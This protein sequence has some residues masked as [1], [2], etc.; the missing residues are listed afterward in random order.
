MTDTTT[1]KAHYFELDKTSRTIRLLSL[2][3]TLHAD[4]TLQCEMSTVSLD[5]SPLYEALSYMWGEPDELRFQIRINGKLVNI[6]QNL[7]HALKAFRS[8]HVALEYR[9][10]LWID[11]LCINQDNIEERNH[12]VGLMGTI[13]RRARAVLIWLGDKDLTLHHKT[14]TA[15]SFS[16]SSDYL[17]PNGPTPEKL[18]A[19]TRFTGFQPSTSQQQRKRLTWQRISE[20]GTDDSWEEVAYITSLPYWQRL[21]IVQEVCL[22]TNIQIL[23]GDHSCSWDVFFA[24]IRY[25]DTDVPDWPP[26]LLS[27]RM[28]KVA[29]SISRSA[30]RRPALLRQGAPASHEL[31]TLIILCQDHQCQDPRDKLYGLLSLA[32]DI[33]DGEIEVDYSK[34]IFEVWEDVVQYYVN[35]QCHHSSHVYVV[36]AAEILQRI[37]LGSLAMSE[38]RFG[39]YVPV[40]IAWTESRAPIEGYILG[41]LKF[42]NVNPSH[43][44]LSTDGSIRALNQQHLEEGKLRSQTLYFVHEWQS[45]L[46]DLWKYD[47]KA[48][49]FP[50]AHMQARNDTIDS[51]LRGSLVLFKVQEH[52]DTPATTYVGIGPGNCR[53]GDLLCCFAGSTV[54]VILRYGNGRYDIIGRALTNTGKFKPTLH[55]DI[56]EDVEQNIGS[57]RNKVLLE[58]DTR[59]LRVLT[60]PLSPRLKS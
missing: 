2:S 46:R 34:S 3:P 32:N 40:R 16:L 33:K 37:F 12:Q 13:Y 52:Q 9:R 10:K 14:T 15:G 6:R 36:E 27:D 5:D 49:A 1:Q 55:D 58:I 31:W 57:F 38:A 50:Q 41:R 21:W 54:A 59:R 45:S 35:H 18:S 44:C 24:T 43:L 47:H 28:S 48:I 4:G 8:K 56:I 7:W 20:S 42:S 51:S 39:M 11:A 17:S 60:C 22:V 53:D 30:A 25:I 19:F 23:Y 26:Y 29:Q